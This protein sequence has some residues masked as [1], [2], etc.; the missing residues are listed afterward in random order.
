MNCPFCQ[1]RIQESVFAQSLNFFAIY[2]IAPI[3][4]G[5]SLIIPKKHIVSMLNLSETDLSEMILF[6]RKVTHIILRAFNSEAF[7]WSVQDQEAAGQT[8]AHLHMHIVPRH[9]TDMPEAG[10]WYSKISN[11]YNRI[12]DSANRTKL[13]GEQMH[14]VVVKLRRIASDEGIFAE[15]G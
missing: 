13:T 10:S 3:F 6:A 4:A 15:N 2:N 8:I 14:Q 12:L 9:N 1:N 5:H 11:N 7:N